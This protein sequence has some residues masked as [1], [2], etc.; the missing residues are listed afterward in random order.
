MLTVTQGA[1]E[2]LKSR[3]LRH[4]TDSE[5]TIRLVPS[6]KKRGKWKMIWDKER[7]KDQVVESRD[8]I[9]ILLLGAEVRRAVDDMVVDFRTT[10]EGTGFAIYRLLSKT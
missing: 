10:A 8:G 9:K 4:K 6:A 3:L 1:E 5:E 2:K 7:P